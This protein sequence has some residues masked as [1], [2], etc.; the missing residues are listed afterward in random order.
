K[1]TVSANLAIALARLRRRVLLV[2]ADLRRPS[3]HRALGL[4]PDT[5]FGALLRKSAPLEEAVI[6]CPDLPNL[7]ILPAGPIKLP[8]DAELLVYGFKNLVEDWRQRFDHII[9]DPPP[10]LAMTDAV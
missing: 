10:V 3:L 2:D 4:D 1:T 9:V 6:G 7:F 8:E 5:G